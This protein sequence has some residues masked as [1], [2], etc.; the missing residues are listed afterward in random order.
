VKDLPAADGKPGKE[1]E[2]QVVRLGPARG[3]QIA[4]LSGLKPG[5]EVVTSG[6]FRLRPHAAVQVNNSVQPGNDLHPKP[7]DS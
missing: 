7:S 1:V 4:V 6:V 2:Q 3:D 5:D